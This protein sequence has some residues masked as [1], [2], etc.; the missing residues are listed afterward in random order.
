MRQWKLPHP[1]LVH[2]VLNP[3]LAFH[4]L[5]LGQRVPRLQL[6]CESCAGSPATRTFV[7]C[8]S[9][10]VVHDARLLS[11][12]NAY[13]NW[14]GIVCPTCSKRIPC[15]WNVTSLAV[16][17]VTAPLWYLPH[18]YYFRDRPTLRRLRAHNLLEPGAAWWR[19][20]LAYGSFMWAITSL[21]PQLL[22]VSSGQH[23]HYRDLLNGA[24]L[25]YSAGLIFG[26]VIWLVSSRRNRGRKRR[27]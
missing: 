2:W 12:G 15:L 27:T 14:L 16:L 11:G 17:G 21:L 19:M 24:L 3:V 18:L 26:F 6:V 10:G 8:P 22:E 20:G 9:C 4:E 5:V 25:W 13:G 7:P 23:F 1:M